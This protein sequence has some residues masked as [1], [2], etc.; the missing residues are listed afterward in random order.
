MKAILFLTPI[1]IC[2]HLIAM[3]FQEF[4]QKA[5]QSAYTLKSATLS[6][7]AAKQR[8]QILQRF[9]DPSITLQGARFDEESLKADDGWAFGISQAIRLPHVGSDLSDLAMIEQEASQAS[10]TLTL[11]SFSKNLETLYSDYV[12]QTKLSLLIKEELALA[13]RLEKIT[14]LRLKNGFGTKTQRMMATLEKENIQTKLEAQKNSIQLSYFALLSFAN[15]SEEPILEAR[16]IYPFKHHFKDTNR[17]N[18]TLLKTATSHKK[19]TKEID[20]ASHSIKSFELFGEYEREPDAKIQRIG[21]SL[22]V[23]L[24]NANKQEM[25]LAKIYAKK[26]ALTLQAQKRVQALEIKSLKNTLQH[27]FKQYSALEKQRKKQQKILRLFEEGYKISK[28]SLFELIA[29]KNRVITK[30]KHL[31]QIQK[32]SNLKQIELHFI[33]GTY[34]D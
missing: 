23:P 8:A 16:F 4:K 30:R 2:T 20:V 27:L 11:A 12:Y 14:R 13:T 15:F 28:G 31:L 22:K 7:E 10:F 17:T 25:Q 34:N 32:E 21:V 5:T 33:Q 29:I 9:E 18:P 6:I 1:L 24:F 3:D 26:S 19:A